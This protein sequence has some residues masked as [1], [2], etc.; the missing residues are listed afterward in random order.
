MTTL[1]HEYKTN[2]TESKSRKRNEIVSDVCGVMR[3]TVEYTD[4][5]Q[6][7]DWCLRVSAL[8]RKPWNTISNR[9]CTYH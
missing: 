6:P 3:L 9:E 7:E 1:V 2:M 8:V 4:A 5:Q